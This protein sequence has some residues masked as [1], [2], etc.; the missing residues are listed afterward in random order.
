MEPVVRHG[1]A[2]IMPGPSPVAFSAITTMVGN[3][4]HWCACCDGLSIWSGATDRTYL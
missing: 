3:R 4:C 1:P 2:G